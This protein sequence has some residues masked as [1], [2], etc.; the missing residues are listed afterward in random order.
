M[1]DAGRRPIVGGDYCFWHD[2]DRQ[3]DAQEARR[4]GGL[5]RRREGTLQGAYNVEVLATIGGAAG[6]GDRRA[7]R[8]RPRRT[9]SP[10]PAIAAVF[11][12]AK[13]AG[14]ATGRNGWLPYSLSNGTP[15]RLEGTTKV[16]GWLVTA[17]ADAGASELPFQKPVSRGPQRRM[18]CPAMRRLPTPFLPYSPEILTQ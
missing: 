14:L 1:N 17:D 7:G 16:N 15:G 4:L 5:R 12:G 13:A 11:A 9:P 8:R 6:P 18:A 2:S 3:V 10:A